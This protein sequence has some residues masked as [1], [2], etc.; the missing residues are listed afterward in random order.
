[1]RFSTIF[2]A[3]SPLPYTITTGF[4]NNGDTI[5]NDRPLGIGRNSVRGAWQRQVDMNLGWTLG[6]VKKKAGKSGS[7]GMIVITSDEASSGDFSVDTTHK[8]TLK[9]LVTARNVF[10]QT[11]FTNYVGVQTSPFFRQ[12][13][14]ADS[15]RRIELGMRFSF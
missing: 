6:L 4:D 1:M 7:P 8:Y 2:S 12:P 15:P 13:I 5:F 10:N 3:A 14:A 11:N 9:F